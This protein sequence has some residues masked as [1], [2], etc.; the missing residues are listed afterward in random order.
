MK[1]LI[2]GLPGSG[3]TT[4]ANNLALYLDA[5]RLN[6]DEIRTTYNDWDFSPEGR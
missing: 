1:I 3:K 2:F 4:L 6:A 5:E